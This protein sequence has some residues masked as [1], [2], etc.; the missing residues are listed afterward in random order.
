MNDKIRPS[1]LERVAFVYVRQSTLHQVRNHQE[2]RRRQY[3]LQN[4]ARELGFQQVELIDEDLGVTATGMKERPGFGRLLAAVCDG[5]AGAVLALEASRLARNNRDWHHLIDLCV[6]T[7]T[8]VIDADGIYDPRLL[9]DRLLLGLKGTMSEFELG[10]LRQRAQEAFR[11]KVSR[12]QV[13]F[14]VPIGY[15]RTEANGVEMTPD[16]QIQEAIRGV[17]EQFQRLGTVRQVLLWYRQEKIPLCTFERQE[18]G[19]RQVAWRL[20]G[21]NRLLAIL[22]NPIY[23]GTFAYGRSRTCSKMV[24]GRARK[25]AGH[26]VPMEQWSVLI[27]DH[28]P[29]YINWEQFMQNQKQL[30]ENTTKYHGA[31]K[32][33]VKRGPA[34]LAGLLRCARCGRK[35][36]VCYTGQGG[37]VVRYHCRGGNINHGVASCQSFGGL[38]ADRAVE[39]LVL[40]ALQPLGIEA[41]LQAWEHSQQEQDLKTKTLALA[42]EKA[43]YEAERVR[44]QY[45][46]VDPTNRLVAAELEGRWN[47]RLMDLEQAKRKLEAAQSVQQPVSQDERKRLLELGSNLESVWSHAATQVTLK[48]RILR[49][50]IEEIV[51]E[52]D[53]AAKQI[54][55]KIHWV[56]GVHTALRIPKN[57]T[58]GH[59]RAA[60]RDVV[61]LV[62]ELVNTCTDTAIASILNRLGYRTGA[63][64]TWTETRVLTL[65]RERSIPGHQKLG[66][67]SWVTL[68]GA[69][70]EL[71]VCPGVIRKLLM[72]K[73][74]PAKQVVENAPWLIKREDLQLEDVQHYVA[75]VHAGKAVPR[76]DNSQIKLPL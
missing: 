18:A 46:A 65:R 41:A 22:T 48:K 4:R 29:G 10:L 51:A 3:E 9:N 39:V 76:H 62:R 16:R 53:D 17:F 63:G 45:E 71:D 25:T 27:R 1:H 36:H 6:L 37:R 56:G 20:P 54:A 44:R 50:L 55:F 24:E 38:R 31:A 23:A 35:L 26:F 19:A 67:D 13:L 68:A 34:L 40:E 69:A 5:R 14:E 72:R 11:Q 61:D 64:N 21:Y 52:V 8:L 30:A 33:A 49:T 59:R 42:L 75:A 43:G 12:G 7:E 73:I 2:S 47:A 32:G 74:L 70:K 28:H 15:V 66:N 58:G 57:H 60:E